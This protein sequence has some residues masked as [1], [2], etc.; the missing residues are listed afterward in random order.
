M[1]T[2][3]RF[4]PPY[5][6]GF[7]KIGE[8]KMVPFYVPPSIR[9]LPLLIG[10]AFALEVQPCLVN[11]Q[12]VFLPNGAPDVARL[13]LLANGNFEAGNRG[14]TSDYGFTTEATTAPGQEGQYTLGV[15][16]Q[17]INGL[18]ASFGDHTTGKGRMMIVNGSTNPKS[19]VVWRQTVSVTP[20]TMYRFTFW[21]ASWGRYGNSQKAI[22]PAQLE[23]AINGEPLGISD[24]LNRIATVP[25]P[26]VVGQWRQVSLLWL[27]GGA[28]A[29]DLTILDRNR[30]FL[31]NDFALDDLSFQNTDTPVNPIL[32]AVPQRP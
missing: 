18:G 6:N 15:N 1:L 29:A 2:K 21:V 11:V 16:P 31:G 5:N 4:A 7:G 24:G 26:A 23:V 20:R 14:F 30:E 22:N 3:S 13:N 27:S 9:F 17:Q 12:A 10:C 28:T 8:K 32:T 25:A 19:P